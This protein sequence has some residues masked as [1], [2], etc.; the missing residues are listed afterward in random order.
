M[1][2]LGVLIFCWLC[3]MLV[4]A[5]KVLVF[6][7]DGSHWVNMNV[8]V[9]RSTD[10]WYIK[11]FSPF[12]TSITLDMESGF[13]EDFL[14]AFIAE[15][16]DIQKGG[17]SVWKRFKLEMEQAKK[18]SEVQKKQSK[19]IEGL[20]ENKALIQ[21]LKDAEYDLVLTDP[22]TPTGAILAQYLKLPL[23]FNVRWTSQGE[24]HFSIAPFPLSY[25][26]IVGSELSD[27]MSFF[28][29]LLNVLIFGFAE[30]QI[31]QYL[32]PWFQCKPA[33]PL[34]QHLEDFVQSS[35][36]H[37]VILMSLGTLIGELPPDLAEAITAAFAKLPQKVIWR[38]NGDRPGTL[39]NNTLLV[40][41]MPQSDLLG[42][43][44]VKRFVAHGGTTGV[45][46]AIY[47]GVPILGLPL[48]F[49]QYDNLFRIKERGA[50]KVIDVFTMN[51]DIFFQGIMERL[52]RLHRDQPIK[53]LD[54]ALFWI[55]FVIRHKGAAHLRT[56]SYKLPWYSYHSI[57]VI[58]FLAA[59]VLVILGTFALLIKCLCSMF[60]R[61]KRKRD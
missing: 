13:D 5:G 30:Y 9:V 21:S 20:L 24:G 38:Y 33:K 6:P 10:S 32:L 15:L 16:L 25:V 8:S 48:V 55:E 47:H 54:N 26:P 61:T 35:G 58:L 42:H 18:T 27:K 11:K 34:P 53:P 29:R 31:A 59:V 46:E 23:V 50:G 1:H 4:H 37:G 40:D 2:V 57:D 28:E 44:K 43:P 3:P 14:T 12:Y 60:L 39:G 45:Q 49:D 36:E 7:V 51:E 22:A 41:W 19:L 52:S 17:M 56:E